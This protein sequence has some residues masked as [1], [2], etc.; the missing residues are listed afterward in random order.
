MIK[1]VKTLAKVGFYSAMLVLSVR[2]TVSYAT[3]LIDLV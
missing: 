3:K 2:S 1:T